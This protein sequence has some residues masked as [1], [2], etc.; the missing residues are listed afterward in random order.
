[1]KEELLEVRT[2]TLTSKG[3]I[4]IPR[5]LRKSKSFREGSKL[6]LLS[7]PSHLEVRPVKQLRQAVH[8]TRKGMVAPLMSE[9][10]LARRW[11]TPE[12]DEAW[13]GL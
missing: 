3:Q 4:A 8:L 13:K 2:V 7:F 10:S 5:A 11:N 12:E 1:M 9:R 6:V